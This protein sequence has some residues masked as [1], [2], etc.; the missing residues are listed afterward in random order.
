MKN[1]DGLKDMMLRSITH[2]FNTPLNGIIM[3]LPALKSSAEIP[4][5]LIASHV[6][7]AKNC[8]DILYS[9]ISDFL[10]F[11]RLNFDNLTFSWKKI[12]LTKLIKESI[13]FIEFTAPFRNIKII[14]EPE[15]ENLIITSDPRRI[16]QILMSLIK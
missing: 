15:E 6:I 1:I 3:L 13:S 16:K 7:P 2:E 4:K 14:F 9:L 11:T 12:N 5:K 10:D 8:S